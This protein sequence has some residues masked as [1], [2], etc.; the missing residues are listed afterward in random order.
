MTEPLDL[1][2]IRTR[3]TSRWRYSDE[4]AD[5]LGDLIREVERLRDVN[6]SGWCFAHEIRL[7]PM[8]DER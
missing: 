1:E 2:P 5:D 6:E 3:L 8:G 7:P 4:T